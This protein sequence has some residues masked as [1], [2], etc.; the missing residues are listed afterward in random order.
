M[1][2]DTPDARRLQILHDVE[3]LIE[4][5]VRLAVWHLS[6]QLNRDDPD[7][8]QV[9]EVIQVIGRILQLRV[10]VRELIRQ[11]TT[12]EEGEGSNATSAH[13]EAEDLSELAPQRGAGHADVEDA[14]VSREVP[15]TLDTGE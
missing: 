14:P 11:A 3:D 7:F 2:V 13:P 12:Q 5:I 6:Q 1:S 15:T 8:D 4:R 10:Q 9:S